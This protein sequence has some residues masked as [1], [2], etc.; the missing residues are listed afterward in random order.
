MSDENMSSDLPTRVGDPPEIDDEIDDFAE[1]A[2]DALMMEGEGKESSDEPEA[3]EAA[4][5]V[6]AAAPGTAEYEDV[7]LDDVIMVSD[8]P[9][10]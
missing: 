2:F 6:D 3:V 7:E 10:E 4:A 5:A 1:S 8:V 9:P